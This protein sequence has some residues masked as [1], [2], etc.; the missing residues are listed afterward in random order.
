MESVEQ[1]NLQVAEPVAGYALLSKSTENSDWRN[2]SHS[3]SLIKTNE[4]NPNILD[5]TR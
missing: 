1:S 5:C 3:A 2:R 4:R